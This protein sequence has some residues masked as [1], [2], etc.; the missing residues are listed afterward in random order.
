MQ[1]QFLKCI[2]EKSTICGHVIVLR[3]WLL[4]CL[5]WVKR[6][7]IYLWCNNIYHKFILNVIVFLEKLYNNLYNN[8]SNSLYVEILS[9]YLSTSIFMC[10]N[11]RHYSDCILSCPNID[12]VICNSFLFMYRDL[13]IRTRQRNVAMK[14]L[15]ELVFHVDREQGFLSRNEFHILCSCWCI[16]AYIIFC[17]YQIRIRDTN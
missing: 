3:N 6:F 14:V 15:H 1:Q 12:R 17:S 11:I 4:F 13:L 9:F 16:V 8:N 7:R 5:L 2:F 10:F